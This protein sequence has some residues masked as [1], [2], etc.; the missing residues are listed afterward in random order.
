VRRDI[1]ITVVIAAAALSTGLLFVVDA[2]ARVRAIVAIAF[3]IIGPGLAL[4]RL[5][6]FGDPLIEMTLAVAVSLALETVIA[7]ALLTNGRWSPGAALTIVILVTMAGIILQIAQ[8]RV[9]DAS[10]E[11]DRRARR[12][13]GLAA[14]GGKVVNID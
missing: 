7:T 13:Q 10:P 3:L 8:P 1:G 9:H 12:R 4:V 6:R 2:D 11:Q 14:P 5:L